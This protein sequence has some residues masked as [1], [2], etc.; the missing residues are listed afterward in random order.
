MKIHSNLKYRLKYY[1][2]YKELM[3]SFYL[4]VTRVRIMKLVG[5]DL[6]Y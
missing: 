3:Y 5:S 2:P 4:H 6:M 1:Q